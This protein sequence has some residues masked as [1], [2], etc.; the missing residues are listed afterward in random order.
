MHLLKNQRNIKHLQ[1]SALKALPPPGG[2]GQGHKAWLHPKQRKRP[3]T[4]RSPHHL[5]AEMA[6]GLQLSLQHT[7]WWVHH[8]V[9]LLIMAWGCQQLW[10]WALKCIISELLSYMPWLTLDQQRSNNFRVIPQVLPWSQHVVGWGQ[11]QNSSCTRI[12]VKISATVLS[13]KLPEG[14]LTCRAFLTLP[15]EAHN[16]RRPPAPPPGL[17]ITPHKHSPQ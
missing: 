17:A 8:S 11:Q 3:G 4:N 1:N 12:F 13:I 6:K 10:F 2:G 16:T 5:P 7:C 15:A 9:L 14:T